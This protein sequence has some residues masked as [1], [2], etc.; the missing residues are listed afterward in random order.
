MMVKLVNM[1]QIFIEGSAV[2]CANDA[3]LWFKIEITMQFFIG[4][5]IDQFSHL[6][7]ILLMG[8]HFRSLILMRLF[9]GVY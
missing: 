4:I 7:F 1:S 6:L 9:V 3:P 2:Y 8:V 5:G